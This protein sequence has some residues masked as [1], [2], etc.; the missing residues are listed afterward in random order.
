MKSF[1]AHLITE[2]IKT[3]AIE[4]GFDKIGIV[5]AEPLKEEGINLEKWLDKGFHGEMKWLEREPEK[6]SNPKVL[7]PEAK[8]MIVLAKNYYTPHEHEDNKTK[9]KISRYAVG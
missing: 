4:I 8:S 5:R 7:F 3:K 6:R 2:N 9:G 1:S